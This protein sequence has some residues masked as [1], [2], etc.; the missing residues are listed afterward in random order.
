MPII[1]LI[2]T[3]LIVI[4]T[5]VTRVIQGYV[6]NDVVSTSVSIFMLSSG[7]RMI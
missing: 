4:T 1:L 2:Y 7:G 5:F 6:L 3:I